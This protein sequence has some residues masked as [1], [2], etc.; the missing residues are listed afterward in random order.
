MGDLESIFELYHSI[1][2]YILD[3]GHCYIG[4]SQDPNPQVVTHR[5]HVASVVMFGENENGY[6]IPHPDLYYMPF[7]HIHDHKVITI[8]PPPPDVMALYFS[9]VREAFSKS[10]ENKTPYIYTADAVQ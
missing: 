3:T 8:M 5:H 9:A 4:I 1:F 2:M 6:L 7:A 10:G